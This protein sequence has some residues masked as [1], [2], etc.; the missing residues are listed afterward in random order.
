IVARWR[1]EEGLFEGD[2][3]LRVEKE[4]E[5]QVLMRTL[6]HDSELGE[7]LR[8]RGP[9][10][11]AARHTSSHRVDELFAVAE[12]LGVLTPEAALS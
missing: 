3:Y 9:Q 12:Q 11:I 4:E 7:R 6:L 8:T 2:E 1:D 10:T 5:M